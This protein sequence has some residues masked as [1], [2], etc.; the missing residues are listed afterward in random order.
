MNQPRQDHGPATQAH[1]KMRGAAKYT[2]NP[3]FA[4]G[5]IY[6]SNLAIVK[7]G[8]HNPRFSCNLTLLLWKTRD[9]EMIIDDKGRCPIGNQVANAVKRC[10]E[11]VV[12]CRK[13][14][15]GWAK[16]NFAEGTG[17]WGIAL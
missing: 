14:E 9:T 8:L 17:A 15:A 16:L 3:T 11:N 7:L 6:L 5:L 4:I 13:P 1:K 2:E 12:P 10:K